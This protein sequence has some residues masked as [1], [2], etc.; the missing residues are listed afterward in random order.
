MIIQLQ[1]HQSI[2]ETFFFGNQVDIFVRDNVEYWMHD[3][4][5][6]AALG[7]KVRGKSQGGT[8]RAS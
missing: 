6:R 8:C 4:E 1:V 7:L 5:P 3:S 2:S